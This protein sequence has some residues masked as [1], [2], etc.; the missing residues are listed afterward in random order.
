MVLMF[1]LLY[2]LAD[3]L[4]GLE[5]AADLSDMLLIETGAVDD[6]EN[7][8]LKYQPPV[9]GAGFRPKWFPTTRCLKDMLHWVGYDQ[10][11]EIADAKDKRPIYLAYRKDAD[12]SRWKLS[13]H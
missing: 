1:A 10:V 13:A 4:S 5:R 7:S 3:P 12:L 11:V 2:H 9:E 8:Y 6:E